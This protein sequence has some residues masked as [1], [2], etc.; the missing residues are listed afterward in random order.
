M[1]VAGIDEKLYLDNI[2][3]VDDVVPNADN[4]EFWWQYELAMDPM[5]N[6]SIFS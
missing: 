4:W 3:N 1:C 5:K 6:Y 2:D